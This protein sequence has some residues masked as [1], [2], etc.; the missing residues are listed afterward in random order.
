MSF[1]IRVKQLSNQFEI[2]IWYVH[3]YKELETYRLIFFKIAIFALLQQ[4]ND[5]IL[6]IGKLS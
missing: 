2:L 6:W 3:S 1:Q 5:S 4:I